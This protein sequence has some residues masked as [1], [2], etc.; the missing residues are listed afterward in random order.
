MSLRLVSVEAIY[1]AINASLQLE[2][3]MWML[4]RYLCRDNAATPLPK[5][6]P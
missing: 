3:I 2:L 4:L 1:E 5:S 6:C